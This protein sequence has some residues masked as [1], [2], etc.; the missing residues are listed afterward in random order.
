MKD[1]IQGMINIANNA[2][3]IIIKNSFFNNSTDSCLKIYKSS[4]NYIGPNITFSN[5]V[6]R[7][8]GGAIHIYENN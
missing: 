7:K 2:K 4:N 1:S 8:N 6:S 3:N 5:C